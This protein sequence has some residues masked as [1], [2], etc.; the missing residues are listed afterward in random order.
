MGTGFSSAQIAA[1]LQ[2]F[3]DFLAGRR[4]TPLLSVYTQ[5]DYRQDPDPQSMVRRACAAIAAD[6]AGG[7]ENILPTFWP[8]FGTISTAA[9]WGGKR[10]MASHGG[11]VH[12]EPTIRSIGE[13]EKLSVRQS[14]AE[15]DFA[16]GLRLYREVCQ[17]LES[18]EIFLRTPDLQGPM[19]TLALVM[20]QTELMCAL[21]EAPQVVSAALDHITDVLIDC[22]GRY[23][24]EAGLGK[25]IGNSWPYVVLPDNQGIAITQ[26]Y[27]PLLSAEAYAEFELPRLKRISEAFGGVWIHCC[28]EYARHLPALRASGIRIM[29][30]EMHHPCTRVEQVYEI[31]GD[32]V[33]YT[34]YVAPTGAAEFPQLADLMNSLAN[35]P[36]A[37][38]RYWLGMCPGWGDLPALRQA[39]AGNF[40]MKHQ[41]SVA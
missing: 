15:S 12:I 11:G 2:T 34:P 21:Y 30:L 6:G 5:P 22:V 17:R 1:T 28:G 25:V 31:F 38:A 37:A 19:N 3:R 29:G 8:D 10:L 18:D 35:K 41:T 14:F 33:V 32:D 23:R 40:G 27:M 13:L 24:Q 7:Q 20:D 9:M 26:D 36:C 16:L 39:L 4:Q